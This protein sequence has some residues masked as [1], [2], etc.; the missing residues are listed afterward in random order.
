MKLII[1]IPEETKQ[2]FDKAES[3]D[4]KGGYYDHGGVIGKA[5]QNGIPLDSDSEKA[6]VQAYFDGQAYGWEEGRK[7]L[8]DDIKAEIDRAYEDV[9]MYYCDEEVCSLFASRVSNILNNIGKG[10]KG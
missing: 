5:I 3:N 10:D 4:L 2:A 7:A 9:T 1:D 6:E 8:I